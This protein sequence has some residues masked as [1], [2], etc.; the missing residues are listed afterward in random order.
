MLTIRRPR[1][2][3]PGG[4][5]ECSAVAGSAAAEVCGQRQAAEVAP[6]PVPEPVVAVAE[7]PRPLSV[8]DV[9]PALPRKRP[10]PSSASSARPS[11]S[12]EL[13]VS[14]PEVV[15]LEDTRATA[16][17]SRVAPLLP[18]QRAVKSKAMPKQRRTEEPIDVE[19]MHDRWAQESAAE[20]RVVSGLSAK[21]QLARP[22]LIY[23]SPAGGRC[24][25]GP[26]N[27]G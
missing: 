23:V 3:S 6:E 12:V 10:V 22:T 2:H 8:L 4:H 21:A 13:A 18:L 25:L 16:S 14:Q 19:A 27:Q 17:S 9:R 26:S 7:A 24:L 1:G 15:D 20:L 5:L 11:S